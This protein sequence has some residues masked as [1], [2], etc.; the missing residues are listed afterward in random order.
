M[1]MQKSFEFSSDSVKL[2]DFRND[3][4]KLLTETGFEEKPINEILLAVQEAVTNIIRHA[5]KEQGK[6]KFS[7][8]FEEDEE[9]VKFSIRDYGKKFDPTKRPD[10]D[11]PRGT[12]GGLGIYLIKNVMDE[13]TY[14]ESF[15]E[16]NLIHLIK[17]KKKSHS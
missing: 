8:Q 16:G 12:P 14:D 3:L 5:Y 4:K 10:P 7:V 6:G 17:Y 13:V 15:T 11:L 1:T 9:K 2:E